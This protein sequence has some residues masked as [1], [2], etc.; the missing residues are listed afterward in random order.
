M[1]KTILAVAML[2]TAAGMQAI[3]PGMEAGG[4]ISRQQGGD[5]EIV[6][7]TS[8]APMTVIGAYGP[9]VIQ[10]GQTVAV[11]KMSFKIQM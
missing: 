4:V 8:K 5:V 10:P 9:V 11:P 2:L 3:L 1:K 7:N 6:S